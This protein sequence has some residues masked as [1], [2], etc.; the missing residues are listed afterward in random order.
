MFAQPLAETSGHKKS[1]SDL[2]EGAARRAPRAIAI[3]SA[4]T[5]L[6]FTRLEVQARVLNVSL[7]HGTTTDHFLRRVREHELTMTSSKLGALVKIASVGTFAE[8]FEEITRTV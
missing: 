8:A 3:P 7:P 5:A 2:A 1:S 4:G 6:T